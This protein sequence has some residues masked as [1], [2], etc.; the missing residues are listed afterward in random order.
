MI[1]VFALLAG[2]LLTACE[3]SDIE[4]YRQIVKNLENSCAVEIVKSNICRRSFV[5]GG[6]TGA[7]TVDLTVRRNDL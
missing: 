3:S 2:L 6:K 7:Y 1:K 5:Y 4:K